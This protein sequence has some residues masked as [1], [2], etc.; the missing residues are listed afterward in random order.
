[1]GCDIHVYAEVRHFSHN[2]QERKNGVWVNVDKWTRSVDNVIYP[3]DYSKKWE[4]DY[5]DRMYKGRNYALFAILADVRNYWDINPISK[6]KGLP[7]N[8]SPEVKDLSDYWGGDGHSHSYLTLNELLSFNWEKETEASDFVSP[9]RLDEKIN[10][11][12]DKYISHKPNSLGFSIT[13]KTTF[14]ELC[15]EFIET[16]EK[17][18]KF[19]RQSD[20]P[21]WCITEDDIRLVFWFDN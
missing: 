16:I 5:V 2:D 6:A 19:V 11:L 9:S 13:Y 10:S 1:M 12:G 21:T 8:I 4:V 14:K 3:E 20:T 18:E 15:A 17:L 7:E